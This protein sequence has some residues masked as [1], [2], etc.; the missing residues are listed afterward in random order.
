MDCYFLKNR[1]VE[2]FDVENFKDSKNWDPQNAFEI[3]DSSN[4]FQHDS[5]TKKK[6][7]NRHLFTKY[8]FWL[9]TMLTI[10]AA[11]FL[12]YN[13]NADKSVMEWIAIPIFAFFFPLIY[14]VYYFIYRFMLHNPC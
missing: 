5:H 14:L 12:S 3:T 2:K 8:C 7:S 13:C 1:I 4:Q 11:V 10:I 9:I 6:R